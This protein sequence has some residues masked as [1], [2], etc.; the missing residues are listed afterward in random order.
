MEKFQ[1]Y[2][3]AVMDT[4]DF[5]LTFLKKKDDA[6]T[7]K[8]AKRVRNLE[9]RLH[10]KQNECEQLRL[11]I[12]NKDRDIDDLALQLKTVQIQLEVAQ[13]QLEPGQTGPEEPKASVGTREFFER[14]IRKMEDAADQANIA[15]KK[16][17]QWIQDHMAAIRA[18][19]Q[20]L[21][22]SLQDQVLVLN[23]DTAAAFADLS[24]RA[25]A[26]EA[27]NEH[28]HSLISSE[29][30]EREQEL[31]EREITTMAVELTRHLQSQS[32]SLGF[33]AVHIELDDGFQGRAGLEVVH[34]VLQR[35]APGAGASD[36]LWDEVVAAQG[37]EALQELLEAG[38]MPQAVV[39]TLKER[40]LLEPLVLGDLGSLKTGGL[41]E[42]LK[43]AGLGAAERRAPGQL[44]APQGPGQKGKAGTKFR[45]FGKAL[46]KAGAG[47]SALQ[48]AALQSA[49]PKLAGG[50]PEAEAALE[51][52]LAE[53]GVEELQEALRLGLLPPELVQKLKDTG[54]VDKIQA[55]DVEG[56]RACKGGLLEALQGAEIPELDEYLRLPDGPAHRNGANTGPVEPGGVYPGGPRGGGKAGARVALSDGNSGFAG[57]GEGCSGSTGS[58]GDPVDPEYA[59]GAAEYAFCR[60][61]QPEWFPT[62][63]TTCGK[64]IKDSFSAAMSG[65]STLLDGADEK[66]QQLKQLVQQSQSMEERSKTWAEQRRSELTERQEILTQTFE[67]LSSWTMEF[68]MP[69]R[70]QRAPHG[71]PRPTTLRDVPRPP[72]N[73]AHT[74]QGTL[75]P[76]R[77][78]H[79]RSTTSTS[80]PSVAST[81]SAQHWAGPVEYKMGPPEASLQSKG[82]AFKPASMRSAAPA[83][84][85][86]QLGSIPPSALSEDGVSWVSRSKSASAGRTLQ[87]AT[88][89][90]LRGRSPLRTH[91]SDAGPQ[92]PRLCPF[93]YVVGQG[94]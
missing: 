8:Y 52:L 24:E 37:I 11:T 87:H 70:S 67:V 39:G 34:S 72:N 71:Q 3:N 49:L 31:I 40:C 57:P 66:S 88:V 73:G 51:Q 13:A 41:L 63:C 33:E 53:G 47:A 64:S 7:Q 28:L 75:R 23:Q 16:A 17:S 42:A 15:R 91:S 26:L 29:T 60:Q 65:L 81:N 94:K 10:E 1:R 78:G 74:K 84:H 14:K 68:D 27:Q 25:A 62:H 58:G 76:K 44:A 89:E 35:L 56:L 32:G 2:V 61:C 6:M 80:T 86:A 54:L 38:H 43:A 83:A 59:A 4:K 93:C 46:G 18:Q 50:G 90:Q 9:E 85:G 20:A 48:R 77:G 69:A 36:E 19:Y 82:P 79:V 45:S 21:K 22:R 55:G 5:N 92:T 30:M 12:K